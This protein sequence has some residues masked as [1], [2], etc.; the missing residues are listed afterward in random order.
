MVKTFVKDVHLNIYHWDFHA[1]KCSFREVKQAWGTLIC[2]ISSPEKKE[3][4]EHCGVCCGLKYNILRQSAAAVSIT[5][6]PAPP[7]P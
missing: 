1:R 6:V 5:V 4:T 3:P 2:R 7:G